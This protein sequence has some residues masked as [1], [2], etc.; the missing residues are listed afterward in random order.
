MKRH[1][2]MYAP[3]PPVHETKMS[4]VGLSSNSPNLLPAYYTAYMLAY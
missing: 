3:Y 4:N 1:E 2:A